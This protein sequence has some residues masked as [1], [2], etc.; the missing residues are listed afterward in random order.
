MS[1]FVGNLLGMAAVLCF[2][3]FIGAFCAGYVMN[4]VQLF[5]CDFT[6]VEIKEMLKIVGAIPFFA[7]LGAI[8]GWIG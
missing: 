6:E 2:L 4:I 7:P 8:M 1:K 5:S 3:A